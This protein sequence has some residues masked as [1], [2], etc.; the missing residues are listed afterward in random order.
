MQFDNYQLELTRPAWLAALVVLPAL[1]FYF[2]RSLVDL[3]RR[4]LL[5][6]LV[7]RT[8]IILLLALSLAGI[9]L[10]S[11]TEQ[12]F[13]I[14]AVDDSLSI[15]DEARGEV[16]RFISESIRDVEAARY[17]VMSRQGAKAQ[18]VDSSSQASES[19]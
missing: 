2:Y 6:S 11:P 4:Q 12:L 16:D 3:P 8:V 13:V 18:S 9:N 19:V 1:V 5:V 14:F 15:D 7:V 17:S 10:L